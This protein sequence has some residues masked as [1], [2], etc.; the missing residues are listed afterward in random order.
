[1]MRSLQTR[2]LLA[3]G[4]LAVAAVAAVA[5]S[6]RLS[7]RL[8]FQRFQEIQK[9][10]ATGDVE[11]MLDRVAAA[12]DG[13]CCAGDVVAGVLPQLAAGQ[14]VFVFDAGGALRVAAGAG[15]AVGSVSAS[16]QGGLLN[17]DSRA[18]APGEQTGMSVTIKGGP[19]KTIRLIDGGKATV[20]IV[21]MPRPDV[22][23][24]AAQFL[25]SVDRRLLIVTGAVAVL[26]LLI[27][28]AI[29]RRI[30]R[31]IA[32][33]RN[34][35]R[36]LAAGQ[37]SRRVAVSGSDEVAELA[38]GFNHMASEL[39]RQESLRRDLVHDVAH[40]LRTPL[41]ALRCRV[42]TVID[43]MVDDPK[44]ALRQVNEDVAHLS[45]LVSDL[46]E[47]ARAEAHELTFAIGDVR[48]ADVCTSAARVAGLDGDPRLRVRMDD[49]ATAKA[50]AVRLRQIVL[51]LLTN[52]DRHTPADGV[53]TLSASSMGAEAL[54]AVHNTGS[55]L[56]A[57]ELSR[58]FDR[59]YRA[60]PARQRATGGSGLGLA[61]VKHLVE[62]QRG[63]VWATSDATGVTFSVA[64][65]TPSLSHRA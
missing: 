38:R 35:T 59:F 3:V 31:P 32:E 49:G 9:V 23:Q 4:L 61:I 41:T 1:M 52:A 29:A 10:R 34:A 50:D 62:A 33:L 13:K 18:T 26:A 21:P 57:E 19:V 63:R 45:Q 6:A 28:G 15:I 27:T 55:A 48:V 8:E 24:P 43:G 7:T 2:L 54:I 5:F 20:L 42:E 56:T 46:E 30:I 64:L 14:A 12:F 16:Y 36:D 22:D 25:G 17:I 60:D 58:V 51:N 44:P 53:I 37:L 40:E 11:A 39:E 47:L 65:P